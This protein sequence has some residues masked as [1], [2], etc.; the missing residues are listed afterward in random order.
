MT[1]SNS[2]LSSVL[3]FAIV[4]ALGLSQPAWSATAEELEAKIQALASQV[5]ALQGEVA[6]LKSQ[7]AAAPATSN[8]TAAAPVAQAPAASSAST[9]DADRLS[10]LGYGELNFSRPTDD[11]SGSTADVGRFVLGAVYRFDDRTRLVSELEVEH[12]IAS[13]DDEGEVEVEQAWIERQL[14]D[15]MYARLGLFLIP[16]GLL[17]ESHEPT[18]YY[19]VFRNFVETAIIPSTWRELGASIEGMTAG[20]LRWD[21][22][23]T[24]G[25]DLSRWDP[26]S[27]E[28]IE[29]P[30]GAIHQEGQLARA[31]DMSGFVAANY[32]GVPGLRVGG[33]IFMGDIDQDQPGFKSNTLTLWEAHTRWTPG[34]WDLSALYAHGQISNTARVNTAFVGNSTLVPKEFYGWYGQAAYVFTL[35]NTWTLAPFA[36]FERVNT[37]SDYAFIGTGLTPDSLR[38]N[39]ISTVGINLGFAPGVVFKLDYQ[40]F[41]HDA[42]SDRVDLGLGYQF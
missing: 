6:A 25:S 37:A 27:S 5:Q 24:T 23:L 30:L 2:G 34:A 13:A 33:S 28:G 14:T 11:S 15:S 17:N 12:A 8:M 7:Q 10:W 9:T 26:T 22:G 4:A 39:E 21:V 29:S 36:R 41:D 19:G 20:G 42:D 16:S 35:P 1:R 3:R 32:T 18:R 38:A 40:A 31:G